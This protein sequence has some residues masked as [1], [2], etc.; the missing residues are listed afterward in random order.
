M[1][2]G[3]GLLHHAQDRNDAPT[4][5][6]QHARHPPITCM[7]AV[8]SHEARPRRALAVCAVLSACAVCALLVKE[9]HFRLTIRAPEPACAS[10]DHHRRGAVRG[11]AAEHAAV[12]VCAR[13]GVGGAAAR[14][15][16]VARRGPP[17]E[18]HAAPRHARHIARPRRCVRAAL[19]AACLHLDALLRRHNL[20][21]VSGAPPPVGPDAY[22]FVANALLRLHSRSLPLPRGRDDSALCFCFAVAGAHRAARA[23]AFDAAPVSRAA[24]EYAAPTRVHTAD[25][26][27]PAAR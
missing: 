20:H 26:P 8:N 24:L 22:T 23:R 12:H 14:A 1:Y 6:H 11:R 25:G 4:L 21:G 13:G 16:V 5:M 17:A 27:L 10:V 15:A 3:L 7:L 18:R 2:R 19:F 9:V